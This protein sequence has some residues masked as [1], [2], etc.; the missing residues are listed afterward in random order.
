M[1]KSLFGEGRL[2]LM[3]SVVAAV[4]HFVFRQAQLDHAI[5]IPLKG[6]GMALLSAY[7][8]SRNSRH[9]AL[10][11]A[12]GALGDMVIML[13]LQWGA[14]AFLVGHLV[15][16]VLY[17]RHR[18]ETLS[19]SQ[20]AAAIAL[21]LLT[22]LIAISLPADPAQKLGV[23]IYSLALGCMAASAWTSTFPR[24][25]VGLGAVLFVASD[26]LIFARMGPMANSPQPTLLIWPLYFAGQY[27]ICTGVVGALR[28]RP[29]Q[30]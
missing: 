11:M 28:S 27:M 12:L 25:R 3:A 16:I 30:S 26:L 9:I 1:A 29:F 24:Y 19:F 21:A 6:A 14:A 8:F 23:G 15:A 10:V 18:R 7:A 13:N 5:G 2:W 4:A 17:L 22:P 20:K